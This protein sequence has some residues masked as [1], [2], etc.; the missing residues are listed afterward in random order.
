MY[1]C[2][3]CNFHRQKLIIDLQEFCLIINEITYPE[4]WAR[5]QF[6]VKVCQYDSEN[7]SRNIYVNQHTF[8]FYG[9]DYICLEF[10]YQIPI[11]TFISCRFYH[12]I[13]FFPYIVIFLSLCL[14]KLRSKFWRLESYGTHFLRFGARMPKYRKYTHMHACI[15]ACTN[16]CKVL[17][18][19]TMFLKVQVS[20]SGLWMPFLTTPY[21][22]NLLIVIW[23]KLIVCWKFDIC[24][25]LIIWAHRSLNTAL[26]Q[27]DL[28][29]F[30]SF[31][32]VQE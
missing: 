3:V 1:A 31:S 23:A 26:Y 7:P 30:Q 9:F 22:R 2:E 21:C 20:V 10:F 16:L 4:N 18:I 15:H 32:R 5:L 12:H 14:W 25:K 24:R 11:Y 8:Q 17:Q 6:N 13:V 27:K 29:P 28:N 19:S